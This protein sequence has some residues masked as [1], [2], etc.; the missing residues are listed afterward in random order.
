MTAVPAGS[1]AAGSVCRVAFGP[2]CA[3]AGGVAPAAPGS[4]QAGAGAFH[5]PP[6]LKVNTT[7]AYQMIAEGPLH[8]SPPDGDS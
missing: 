7:D 1:A 2:V 6:T 4:L 5:T 8:K 3:K